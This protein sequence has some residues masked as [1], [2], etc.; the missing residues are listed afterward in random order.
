MLFLYLSWHEKGIQL[1]ECF[2]FLLSVVGE[3]KTF[4]NN[5]LLTACFFWG[6]GGGDFVYLFFANADS[7]GDF[8]NSNFYVDKKSLSTQN[9]E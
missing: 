4:F 1:Y 5:A 9:K 8:L 2:F 6:G 3:T 7:R